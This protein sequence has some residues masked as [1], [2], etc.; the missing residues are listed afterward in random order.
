L[1]PNPN[2]NVANQVMH[3][4]DISWCGS[5]GRPMSSPD[6]V[7][8]VLSAVTSSPSMCSYAASTCPNAICVIA[9]P[10]PCACGTVLQSPSGIPRS[11]LQ[12]VT[13][14]LLDGT[15][16]STTACRIRRGDLW[17]RKPVSIGRDVIPL[18]PLLLADAR[19]W[20]HH[21]WTCRRLRNP[22]KKS[23]SRRR[24]CAIQ[25]N[26]IFR[27]GKRIRARVPG[28]L[29]FVQLPYNAN[30]RIGT[31][32]GDLSGRWRINGPH[33]GLRWVKTDSACSSRSFGALSIFN[34]FSV[35][36]HACIMGFSFVLGV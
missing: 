20:S 35:V 18:R 30:R 3:P 14:V 2:P 15:A 24:R 5:S 6:P 12:R 26:R 13:V 7:A 25:L 8:Y 31:T 19:A 34:I 9:W 1:F 17:H 32:G 4:V 27:E 29:H 11:D 23:R 21:H 22:R 36:G 10:P 16:R 28:V 33:A